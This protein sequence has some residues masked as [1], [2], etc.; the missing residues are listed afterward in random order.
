VGTDSKSSEL[1]NGVF[2]SGPGPVRV[3][4]VRKNIL[5]KTESAATKLEALLATPGADEQTGASSSSTVL[6]HESWDQLGI[7]ITATGY[8]AFTPCPATGATV[9]LCQGVPLHL[10]GKKRWREVLGCFAQSED[11]R[12]A[13][14][15]DLRTRLGYTRK[16]TISDSQAQHENL[17][18]SKPA[19]TTLKDTMADLGRQLRKIFS[20][21]PKQPVF[22]VDGSGE[23]YTAPFTTRYLLNAADG[24]YRFARG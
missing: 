23:N 19:L 11:G 1:V 6:C 16:G 7:G 21:L 18:G 5:P 13:R 20:D 3:L 24:K 12:T 15:S 10:K 2:G 17:H 9:S 8:R 22:T 14:R 4:Y